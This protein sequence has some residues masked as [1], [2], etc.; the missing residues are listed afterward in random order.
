VELPRAQVRPHERRRSSRAATLQRANKS[1]PDPSRA[2]ARGDSHSVALEES[3]SRREPQHASLARGSR[4]EIPVSRARG[5]TR[6]CHT[7]RK[8][9]R[10][11]D[12]RTTLATPTIVTRA[13]QARV[14]AGPT[15]AARRDGRERGATPSP[16]H[17]RHC[18]CRAATRQDRFRAIARAS[19]LVA[20]VPTSPPLRHAAVTQNADCSVHVH[21]QALLCSFRCS[22]SRCNRRD[23]FGRRRGSAGA[24]ARPPPGAA[25]PRPARRLVP[26]SRRDNWLLAIGND[27]AVSPFVSNSLSDSEF[28]GASFSPDGE[29]LF[30]N[31]QSDGLTVAIWG[32]WAAGCRGAAVRGRPRAAC[33]GAERGATPCACSPSRASS[34]GFHGNLELRVKTG[35]VSTETRALAAP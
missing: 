13:E 16:S 7:L 3:A 18:E 21:L 2:C 27:G 1:K 8:G 4:C 6:G 33:R 10:R 29:T 11:V 30:A 26:R 9:S 19:S 17:W 15:R 14:R 34:R 25:L 32:P 12:S 35:P 23:G 20:V 5:R 28:A 22:I 24:R 31:I